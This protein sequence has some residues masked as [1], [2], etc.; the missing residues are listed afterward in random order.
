M[1]RHRIIGGMISRIWAVTAKSV[2]TC[3]LE[4]VIAQIIQSIRVL[5]Q[6]RFQR[7]VRL[8]YV[9]CSTWIRLIRVAEKCLALCCERPLIFIMCNFEFG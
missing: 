4:H 3:V 8:M 9:L 2:P 7:F 5:L 1:I 6:C